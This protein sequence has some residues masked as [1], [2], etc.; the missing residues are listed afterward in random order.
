MYGS[1]REARDPLRTKA[2]RLMKSKKKFIFLFI[3]AAAYMSMVNTNL[4]QRARLLA[5]HEELRNLW[6]EDLGDGDCDIGNPNE[7]IAKPANDDANKTLLASYPGSGKRFTWTVIKALTN[8]E[9]A[10]DWNFSS[11]LNSKPLSIKTSWPHKE[12]VWTWN[13]QMDQV[14]MLMRNPRWAIPSYHT[15]RWELDYSKDWASSY[16]RIPDTYTERPAVEQWE[17]WRDGHFNTEINRWSS[18]VDF[19]MQGGFQESRNKTH[20][21]CLYSEIECHPKAIID[22]DHFYQVRNRSSQI[23]LTTCKHLF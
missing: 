3:A 13:K 21:R 5:D 11:K 18:F 1:H 2:K 10:D 12:G 22:F 16:V 23:I 20:N 4:E 7:D 6:T 17:K 8:T 15:M 9:I 19:W 14:I